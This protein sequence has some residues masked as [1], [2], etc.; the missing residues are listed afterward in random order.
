MERHSGLIKRGGSENALR[1]GCRI[2]LMK[3]DYLLCEQ[4]SVI[5]LIITGNVS[6]CQLS[7]YQVSWR[8]AAIFFDEDKIPIKSRC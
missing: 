3:V 7:L 4:I 6:L 5:D 8:P 1:K 2:A